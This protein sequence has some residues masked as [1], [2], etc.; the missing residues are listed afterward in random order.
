LPGAPEKHYFQW[1]KTESS[2]W[3]GDGS[4]AKGNF[5]LEPVNAT[6]SNN[7]VS[8]R[9]VDGI[10]KCKE[11][12]LKFDSQVL[13]NFTAYVNGT[14]HYKDCIYDTGE[15]LIGSNG[16]WEAF[17][18]GTEDI[19]SDRVTLDIEKLKCNS[20]DYDYEEP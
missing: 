11:F 10:L 16:T 12:I 4:D 9:Y 19:K 5:V 20:D 13:K 18:K 15:K 17:E 8:L 14:V 6:T 3:N 1:N 2:R 7:L